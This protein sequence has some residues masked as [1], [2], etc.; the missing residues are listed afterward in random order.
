MRVPG[1]RR[2]AQLTKGSRDPVKL[3]A[4][5]FV[6]VACEIRSGRRFVQGTLDPLAIAIVE[7][8]GAGKGSGLVAVGE[9][10]YIFAN[11]YVS[12]MQDRIRN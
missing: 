7:E 4:G 6:V 12:F 10:T 9:E 5:H 2:R 3:D 1:L 11:P 8:C